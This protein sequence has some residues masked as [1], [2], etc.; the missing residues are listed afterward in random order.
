MIIIIVSHGHLHYIST[1]KQAGIKF[2]VLTGHGFW[3]DC[4]WFQLQ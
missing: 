1:S 3:H 4:M 2:S